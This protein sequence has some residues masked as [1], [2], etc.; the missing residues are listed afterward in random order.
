MLANLVRLYLVAHDPFM[1]IVSS[2]KR[3]LI[4]V[5]ENTIG[6]SG[7][8]LY[9]GLGDGSTGVCICTLLCTYSLASL[10]V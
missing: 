3:V 7:N 2:S 6:A 4:C 5:K 10:Y 9:P 8:V 1:Y